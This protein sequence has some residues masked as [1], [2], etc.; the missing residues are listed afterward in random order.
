MDNI[1]SHGFDPF[2]N[3]LAGAGGLN[4]V[5]AIKSSPCRRA[6]RPAGSRAPC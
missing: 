3:M 6:L 1:V 5:S 4:I 2:I